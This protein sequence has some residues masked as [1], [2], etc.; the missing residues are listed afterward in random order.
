MFDLA[1]GDSA[2]HIADREEGSGLDRASKRIKLAQGDGKLPEI[3]MAE[4]RKLLDLVLALFYKDLDD[5]D[6]NTDPFNT[7]SEDKDLT[8]RCDVAKF[9]DKFPLNAGKV[10]LYQHLQSLT[11]LP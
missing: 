7:I 8:Q 3:K 9:F 6:F 1:Q 4:N 5:V 10:A 2:T 11:P